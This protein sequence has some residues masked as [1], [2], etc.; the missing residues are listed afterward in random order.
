M[1]VYDA[2][3]VKP[4]VS[5]MR[6]F[7]RERMGYQNIQHKQL[8]AEAAWRCVVHQLGIAAGADDHWRVLSADDELGSSHVAQ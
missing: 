4:S 2:L 7:R 8:P 6:A 3:S 1:I 5:A